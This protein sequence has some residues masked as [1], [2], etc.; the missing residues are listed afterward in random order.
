[1]K[2]KKI[3]DRVELNV[4]AQGCKD[5][6]TYWYAGVPL[7]APFKTIIPSKCRLLKNALWSKWW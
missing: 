1:M 5:D 2:I 6:C 3:M 4:S 7:V